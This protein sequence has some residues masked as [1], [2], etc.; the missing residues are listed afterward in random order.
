MKLSQLVDGVVAKDDEIIITRNGRPA[1]VIMN[2]NEYESWKETHEIMADKELM[3]EI[4]KN[5][6]AFQRG[7]VKK[8]S[9]DELFGP[10]SL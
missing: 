6:D 10:E 2:N 5:L 1:A 3:K 9:L 7:Q 4:Q 8:Y